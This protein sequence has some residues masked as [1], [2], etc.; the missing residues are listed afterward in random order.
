A[1]SASSSF[2]LTVNAGND[3]PRIAYTGGLVAVV[4]Q[5]LRATLRAIDPD[6]D[7]L[8]WTA[9]GLPAG[10]TLTAGTVYGTADLRWTPAAGDAG[11][12]P[13]TFRVTDGT[14]SDMRTVSLVV[15]SANAAP[16]V[17][18]VADLL[19]HEG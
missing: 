10:A 8:T 2:V 17:A 4:G 7:S 12:H 14:G 18:P 16:V 3:P 19:A 13:V 5:E 6:Q 1:L 15:R 9:D 11:Q